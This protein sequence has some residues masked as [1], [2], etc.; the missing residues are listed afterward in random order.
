MPDH[1]LFIVKEK[2]STDISYNVD[3]PLKC[4]KYFPCKE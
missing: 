2:S 1:V 4:A 3:E